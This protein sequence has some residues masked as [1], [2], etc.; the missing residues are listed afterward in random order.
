MMIL[1]W[2][3]SDD[4]L[5]PGALHKVAMFLSG[6]DQPA[7]VVGAS[8]LVSSDGKQLSVRKAKV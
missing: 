2:I 7:W 4:Y 6:V 8:R 5:E 1:G 3:N